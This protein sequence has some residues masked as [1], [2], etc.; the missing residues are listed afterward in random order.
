MMN[1]E[2]EPD[3]VPMVRVVGA[4]ARRTLE[5]WSGGGPIGRASGVVVLRSM[6]DPQAVTMRIGDGVLRIERGVA[7]DAEVIIDADLGDSS[8]KPRVEGAARHP[9]L[10]LAASKLLD[11]P[12]AYWCDEADS[13]MRKALAHRDCP[14]PISI[15]C[16]DEGRSARWGGDGE[17]AIE[18]HGTAELLAA[19]MSGS[20]N[21]AEEVLA[22]RLYVV[23]GLRDLS[24][25]TRLT[26]DHMFGEL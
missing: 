24:M 11:P 5:R 9:V 19:A 18:I 13:F 23:G 14:R 8:A 21:V 15:V 10:A 4:M 12:V 22:G 20:S 25:L 2:L 17:P 1:V 26:I 3:A 16:T 6:N 7:G